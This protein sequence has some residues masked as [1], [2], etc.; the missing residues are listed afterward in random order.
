M[1]DLSKKK[2]AS[3]ERLAGIQ[4]LYVSVARRMEAMEALVHLRTELDCF[5]Q[6]LE[7]NSTEANILFSCPKDC[8][9][10]YK[11]AT[12]SIRTELQRISLTRFDNFFIP[13][14][15]LSSIDLQSVNSAK[16]SLKSFIIKLSTM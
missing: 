8:I 12:G 7:E 6:E 9:S 15:I 14:K 5:I 10:E 1:K 13:N 11:K 16:E 2:N 3:S 4:A